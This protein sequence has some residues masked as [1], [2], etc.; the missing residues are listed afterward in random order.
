MTNDMVKVNEMN[1]KMKKMNEKKILMKW[2][3]LF[4]IIQLY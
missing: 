4:Q 3:F 1:E 2:C